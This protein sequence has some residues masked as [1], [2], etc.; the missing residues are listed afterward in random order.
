[1]QYLKLTIHCSRRSALNHKLVLML[2]Q[3]FEETGLVG[4]ICFAGPDPEKG[5]KLM[6]TSCV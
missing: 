5:G 6:S 3:A 2:D 4:T 1:M